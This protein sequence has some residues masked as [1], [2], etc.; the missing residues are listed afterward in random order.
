VQG[1]HFTLH[2]TPVVALPQALLWLPRSQTLVASD[3]HFEKGSA[4]AARGTL[5]PPFDTDE[6]LD[7]LQRVILALSPRC[8]IAL[9][10]SF[11]DLGA[12]G[13]LHGNNKDRLLALSKNTPTIWIEGNH[14]PEVPSWLL[15]DRCHEISHDGLFFT[16][17]PTGLVA[18]EVGGH[19]HPCARICGA[20]GR[21]LRK[22]CFIS[23][24]RTLVMPSF[25]AFTG[26]LNVKDIAFDG[27]FKRP[28][29]ALVMGGTHRTPTRV[30]AIEVKKLSADI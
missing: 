24:G 18:G 30:R 1:Y 8:L 16:H 19:L 27:L 13:R 4:F 15:G 21:T 22:R 20:S 28:P 29:V 12:Q 25:G 14:D 23:D 5:L 3:L 26:G 9:G 11:H 17:E 7:R 2:E 10:D 6:T